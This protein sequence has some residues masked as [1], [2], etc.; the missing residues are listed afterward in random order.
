MD[1]WLIRVAA[2]AIGAGSVGVGAF[3]YVVPDRAARR[4]GI[5]P[6]GDPASMIMMR[7]AGARDCFLGSALL[8]AAARGGDYRP[9]LAMRAAADAADGLAGLLALRAGT[10]CAGQASTT[11]S[12]LVLSG[13]EA[14]LWCI[15]G[16][17]RPKPG[18]MVT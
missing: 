3:Q 11:R 9:W 2:G 5:P 13:V 6:G 10:K 1:R 16:R 8:C 18:G 7:G 17:G 15:S 12:A 14:V 4:F